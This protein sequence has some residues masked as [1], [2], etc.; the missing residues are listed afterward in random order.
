M[1]LGLSLSGGGVRGIAHIGVLQALQEVNILPT[2]LAGVS[3][4]AMVAAL[5]AQGLAPLEI[6]E[7][8]SKLRL[9]QLIKP[10][11]WGKMGLFNLEKMTDV[12]LRYIPHNSFEGLKIPL[13][14]STTD[15]QKGESVLFSKGELIKP[16]LASCSIPFLF[17]PIK[18]NGQTMVDG[19]ILNGLL[20][21]PIAQCD[22]K[23]GVHTNSFDPESPL[24]GIRSI[25]QRCFNLVLH[26]TSRQNLN[27]FDISLEPTELGYYSAT[28][29]RK[30]RELY[31]IGYKSTQKILPALIDKG[32]TK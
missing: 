17:S 21:E 15:V 32:L 13:T 10:A 24:K 1:T 8:I 7:L 3:A 27:K 31:E 11:G 19:G 29:L 28:N 6:L 4:G 18:I 26:N 25:L 12:L 30:A 22:V 14:L 9:R 20:Y 2:Q 23:M 5:Y 16:L